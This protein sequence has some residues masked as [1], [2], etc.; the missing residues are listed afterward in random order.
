MSTG[1]CNV[2]PSRGV[3][4][5]LTSS[6]I[7]YAST[8]GWKGRVQLPNTDRRGESPVGCLQNQA[9]SFTLTSTLWGGK[10]PLIPLTRDNTLAFQSIAY[11]TAIG[12]LCAFYWVSIT[13]GYGAKPR[14]QWITALT[15]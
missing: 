3:A 8:G 1:T 7:C 15:S 11:I 6:V 5:L 4:E 13:A 2:S 12:T 9:A 10:G 14:S